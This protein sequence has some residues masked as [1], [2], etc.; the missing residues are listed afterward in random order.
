LNNIEK[1]IEVLMDILKL[2]EQNRQLLSVVLDYLLHLSK[3][4]VN[5]EERVRRRSVKLRYIL[6]SM[7]VDG[8]KSGEFRKADSKIAGNYLYSFIEA[9]IYQLVVLKRK[10]L[11]ELKETIMFA[12]RQF[13]E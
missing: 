12:A 9:G 6:S 7:V 10:N 11:N 1:I 4:G 2:L 8:V 5:P 13:S 3:E